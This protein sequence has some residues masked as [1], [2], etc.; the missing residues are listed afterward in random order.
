MAAETD[1][2]D[3]FAIVGT[4]GLKHHGGMIDEEWHIKLK[5]KRGVRF[6]REMA[7]NCAVVGAFLF[8][9]EYFIRQVEWR[10]VPADESERGVAAA[11]FLEECIDDM[12]LTWED[13]IAESLTELPFGWSYFEEVYKRRIGPDEE[14]PS[15]RSRFT[16]GRISWRKFAIRGQETLHRWE[17]DEDGG[18]RGMWQWDPFAGK[19][20]VFIPIEKALLF[21]TKSN[22]N[23]PEGRSV[24]RNAFRSWRFLRRMQEIEA[25]G[26]ERDL[27]GYPVMEV[28]LRLLKTDATVGDKA[29]RTAFERTIQSIRRDDREGALVPPEV[30]VNGKPTGYKLKLLTTGGRRQ[31]DPDKVIRRYE[32]RIL[33]TVLHDWI[34][35]GQDKV[36]SFALADTKTSA[37]SLAV[38]GFLGSIASPINRISIPRL[39]KLNPEFDQEFWPTV[40]RGDIEM[41]DLKEL[42]DFILTLTKGG[43]LTP[44]AALE[45][46]LRHKGGLPERDEDP[47]LT[48][49]NA[50]PER[51]REPGRPANQTKP[52]SENDGDGETIQAAPQPDG[53]NGAAQPTGG[54]Q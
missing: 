17:L 22:K 27:A 3:P 9:I 42:A 12:S 33:G 23:N 52:T 39:M 15:K 51:P 43:A 49:R 7:D 35:M 19:G 30:D 48:P 54:A 18:I 34:L 36:G 11:Q 4:T 1:N 37:S 13:F 24:L 20:M 8:A 32:H 45:R 53:T 16:D 28:P 44:D 14:D 29:L 40:E 5:G 2:L 38:A 47:D 10:V 6:Y 26:I 41:P 50:D 46:H 21:R 25:I 31:L